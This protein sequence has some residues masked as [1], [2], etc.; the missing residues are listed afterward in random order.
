MWFMAVTAFY[1]ELRISLRAANT[2]ER[3]M[4]GNFAQQWRAMW[5]SANKLERCQSCREIVGYKRL[6]DMVV[7]LEGTIS[8]LNLDPLALTTDSG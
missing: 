3:A 7:K 8:T 6:Q 2:V 5:C 1:Y 4:Y